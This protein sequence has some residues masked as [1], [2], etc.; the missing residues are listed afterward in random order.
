MTETLRYP[1]TCT[2]FVEIVEIVVG[3]YYKMLNPEPVDALIP[4]ENVNAVLRRGNER[5]C[6][7]SRPVRNPRL[8]I[9]GVT[10]LSVVSDEHMVV[11]LTPRF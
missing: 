2:I 5:F 9:R 8:G 4:T 10:G 1:S 3:M 11:S 6:V 7:S